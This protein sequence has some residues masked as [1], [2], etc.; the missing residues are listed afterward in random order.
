MVDVHY[1]IFVLD[2]DTALISILIFGLAFFLLRLVYRMWRGSQRCPHCGE[3]Y[4]AHPPVIVA[5]D[6]A[7]PT[8]LWT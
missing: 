3:F 4:R 1:F 8:T 6:K 5:P 2:A 7:L